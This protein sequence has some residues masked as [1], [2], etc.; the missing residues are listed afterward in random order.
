[1]TAIEFYRTL[2]DRLGLADIEEAETATR[3]VLAALADRI[4]DDEANDLASQLPTELGDF[5]RRRVGPPQE[6]DMETFISRIQSDLDL[7]EWQH[8]ADVTRGVFSV[9]KEAVSEGEWRDVVSQLP[10]ELQD[11]FVR[12]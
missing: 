1:M 8:A 12:A 10:A 11:M 6:M 4:T 5:I 9:L 2:R 7:E 3:S